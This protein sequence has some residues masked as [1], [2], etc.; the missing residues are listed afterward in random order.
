MRSMTLRLTASNRLRASAPPSLLTRRADPPAAPQPRARPPRATAPPLLSP[1][2]LV[3]SGASATAAGCQSCDRLPPC[4]KGSSSSSPHSAGLAAGLGGSSSTGGCTPPP[5]TTTTRVR[6]GILLSGGAATSAAPAAP[7]GPPPRRGTLAP[8]PIFLHLAAALSKT[9]VTFT[10]ALGASPPPTSFLRQG[11]L[12][13]AM[14]CSA[15]EPAGVGPVHWRI[16]F[17]ARLLPHAPQ[18]EQKA[19][20]ASPSTSAM[21]CPLP[22]HVLACLWAICPRH[23]SVF[24]LTVS[25]SPLAQ[26]PQHSHLQDP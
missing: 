3:W 7:S 10:L 12:P 18:R 20:G 8:T 25:A 1:P 4:P 13:L 5:P 2:P 14:R 16:R 26:V 21:T 24:C 9:V 17:L 19:K 23:R 6:P 11:C 15:W 22:L